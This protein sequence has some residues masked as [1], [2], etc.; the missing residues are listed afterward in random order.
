MLTENHSG[1][2]VPETEIGQRL[3]SL[4]AHLKAAGIHLAWIENPT[5]LFYYTGTTQQGILLVRV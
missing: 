3:A 4:Q 2:L 1:Y 5:D